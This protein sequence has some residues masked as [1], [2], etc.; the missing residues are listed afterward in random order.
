MSLSLP[1]TPPPLPR[2][3]SIQTLLLPP[4]SPLY[5]PLVARCQSLLRPLLPPPA[6]KAEE[7]L[8]PL[9]L[10]VLMPRLS[11]VS[12][13]LPWVLMLLLPLLLLPPLPLLVGLQLC[14]R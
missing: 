3:P 5:T 13:P 9:V 14:R 12:P 11:W 6:E 10:M 7:M 1:P 4:P 2:C 8:M